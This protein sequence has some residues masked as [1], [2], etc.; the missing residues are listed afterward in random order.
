MPS[1]FFQSDSTGVRVKVCG[2]TNAAD[3]GIAAEAGADAIG[4]V[5]YPGSKRFVILPS[6][7]GWLAELTGR[8]ARVALL[9]N[10]THDEVRRVLD[11][12]LVDAV[13]LHGDETPAFCAR[14]TG[15]G[16]PVLKALRMRSREILASAAT[17]PVTAV[18][19]D[20]YVEKAYGGTGHTFDWQWLAGFQMPFILSGGLTPHNVRL[21]VQTSKPLAV[22][23]SSG[24]ETS[25]GRK[26]PALVRAFIAQAKM[27]MPQMTEPH[28]QRLT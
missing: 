23:V 8:V 19:L 16:K 27:R 5:L 26:D 10:P 3:A 15:H 9:V 2:I 21:A 7:A 22:D 11:N 28:L 20:A 12:P 25:P 14:L 24:V 4:I 13:Q 1:S 18:L 17:Y 6:A